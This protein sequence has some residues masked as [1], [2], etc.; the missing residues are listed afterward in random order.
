MSL[1]EALEKHM[2]KLHMPD[3][4]QD[5]EKNL[6]LS[7]QGVNLTLHKRIEELERALRACIG[8]M[9]GLS[10]VS[11]DAAKEQARAVLEKKS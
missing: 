5:K 2:K 7:L 4:P 8:A 3:P 10:S 11:A 9:R 1:D 6:I